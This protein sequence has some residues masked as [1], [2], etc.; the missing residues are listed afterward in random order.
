MTLGEK[1]K[2]ARLEAGLS[3]RQLCGDVITRNMLSQIENGSANP[4][5]ATLQYLAQRLDKSVSYFLQ[6]QAV[7]SPNPG[8]M[9]QARQAYGLGRFGQTLEILADYYGPDPLFDQ[10][11][12]YLQALCA[13]A[14]GE[15]LLNI[16]DA[17]QAARL[18]E[19]IH[20]ECIYYRADMERV[21]RQLLERA[22]PMLEEQYRTQGDFEQ[23]YYCACKLRQLPK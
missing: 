3:Q 16:G 5:M 7:E 23:A 6:E 19:E 17:R 22:Y 12:G 15:R 4:S 2:A 9:E 1:L 20:R 11:Y 21:R 8:V 18:L 14:E 13:L 10:E